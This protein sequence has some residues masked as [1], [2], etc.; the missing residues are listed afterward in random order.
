MKETEEEKIGE[1]KRPN[2]RRRRTEQQLSCL[3]SRESVRS[4]KGEPLPQG[5]LPCASPQH[6]PAGPELRPF[7]E[8][9]RARQ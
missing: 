3:Y 7:R 4:L 1:I 5:L 9:Q 6:K 8:S 2:K